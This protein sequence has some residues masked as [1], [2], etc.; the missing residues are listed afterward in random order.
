LTRYF[1]IGLLQ[2]Q[3]VDGVDDEVRVLLDTPAAA[4]DQVVRRHVREGRPED[5]GG[6]DD[7]EPVAQSRLERGDERAVVLVP[8]PLVLRPGLG[9][10]GI[11]GGRGGGHPA[12]CPTYD[13]YQASVSR[14][15][16]LVRLSPVTAD[17]AA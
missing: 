11:A 5:V 3:P 14:R 2:Q 9:D 7:V 6:P 8:T 17:E 15:I 13:E 16:S 10:L 4:A 12:R 1:A